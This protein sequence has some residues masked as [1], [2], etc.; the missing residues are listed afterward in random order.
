MGIFLQIDKYQDEIAV[1]CKN[2][3]YTYREL[4]SDTERFVENIG[5]R[6]LIF[7][8]CS[9]TYPSLV[10][11]VGC[12]RND[13]V[14][15]MINH[16]MNPEMFNNLVN[17]YK[18]SYLWQ[19]KGFSEGNSEYD[20][21]GYELI[22]MPNQ[23]YPMV[24]DLALLLTT[25]GSTGSPKYVKQSYKN[26][27]SNAASIIE[28]LGIRGD[29]RAITTLPMSYTYGLSI[30]NTHLIQGGSVVLTDTPIVKKEFWE[31]LNKYGANNFGGVPYTYET[32]KRLRFER[33][34]VPSLRYITQAGGKLGQ[35][36]H[37]LFADIC[38]KK[39]I[40][41]IVMYGQT[42][43]TARMSY[44]PWN[45]SKEKAGSIGIAIPGGVF[46]LIDVDD[47]EIT[48]ANVVGELVY[49][50]ENVTMGYAT[51]GYDLDKPDE[52]AGVLKT[53]DMAYRDGDGFY[54]IAGR[55]K[56]FLKIYGNRLN[57]DEVDGMMQK[58]GYEAVASGTDNH[59]Q[60]YSVDKNGQE[61]IDFLVK[62]TGLNR[63][64][65]E[66]NYIEK[67]PRNESG[68]VLYTELK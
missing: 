47:K 48:E 32:L 56:R 49:H 60:I 40:E 10:G 53:G 20:F 66:V 41:I 5:G 24:E 52:R 22:K 13:I 14:P 67:I 38:E 29:D 43:A 9:N 16:T 68:K 23:S 4:V 25:S 61:I 64:A 36:L 15:L 35:E 3:K 59:V 26:I 2:Q 34:N 42:E 54:Y 31:E 33:M 1:I 17:I 8:V 58:A 27:E 28:Y 51:S 62:Q 11:Y 44:L 46:S 6:T 21:C 12:L 57:L 19:P 30:I 50:G 18:P 37:T 7:L 65:F 63:H 45:I 55:K 39:G